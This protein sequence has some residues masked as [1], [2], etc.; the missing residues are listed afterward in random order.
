MARRKIKFDFYE[1][2]VAASNPQLPARSAGDIF[3]ILAN[4]FAEGQTT[5]RAVHRTQFDVRHISQTDYGYRGVIGKYRAADLPH[6][7]APGGEE[8]EIPLEE[9]ERLLEKCYFKYFSD[10]SLLIIQRNRYAINSKQLSSYLTANSY[11]FSLDPVIEAADL[12]RLMRNEVHIRT[13]NVKIA[14]PTNPALFQNIEHDFNNSIIQSLNA[15]NGA[16]VNITFRGDGHSS[17]PER[18]YLDNRLKRA[19]LEMKEKFD[20]QSANLMLEEGDVSHPLDLI[21]DRL[22]H[23]VDIELDGR[24]PSPNSMWNAIMESRRE[25]EAELANYFGVLGEARIE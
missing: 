11:T 25:K 22:A 18:R 13:L 20:L 6:A 23:D 17:D 3:A 8:R 1:C 5:V 14:R 9:N 19:V 10:Y 21:A 12:L 24:Y 7:A 4:A 16:S 2:K 15:S